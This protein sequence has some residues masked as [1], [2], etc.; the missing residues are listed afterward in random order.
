MESSN[1]CE[2]KRR[3]QE[4]IRSL[5]FKI[6]KLTLELEGFVFQG[7]LLDWAEKGPMVIR[8]DRQIRDYYKVNSSTDIIK[9]ED[10]GIMFVPITIQLECIYPS[11]SKN[12]SSVKFLPFRPYKILKHKEILV[13]SIASE[14][15]WSLPRVEA[16]INKH[17]LNIPQIYNPDLYNSKYIVID[18]D[19]SESYYSS[20]ND[21]NDMLVAPCY[22]R[23][24]LV[25]PLN[26]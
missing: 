24:I 10:E 25:M 20:D 5:K 4:K 19:S 22:V 26:S 11:W 15:N 6:E 18:Y 8:M 21:D 1:H 14:L 2:L 13:S 7:K 12:L 9:F 23:Y 17:I 3:T 16:L